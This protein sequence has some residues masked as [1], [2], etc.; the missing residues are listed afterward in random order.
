MNRIYLYF[1]NK[2]RSKWPLLGLLSVPQLGYRNI[3]LLRYT[4]CV[5]LIGYLNQ[6]V[7]SAGVSFLKGGN[8]RN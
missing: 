8:V 3:Q 2:H 1:V 5:F 6:S 7:E 4:D